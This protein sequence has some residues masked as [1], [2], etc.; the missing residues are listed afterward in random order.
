M[1]HPVT[2]FRERGLRGQK[3]PT[4]PDANGTAKSRA[5]P[6]PALARHDLKYSQA[7]TLR[8]MGPWFP[9]FENHEEWGNLTRVA[10]QQKSRSPAL[11]YFR[12]PFQHPTHVSEITKAAYRRV[13]CGRLSWM[14]DWR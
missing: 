1:Q 3:P 4:L 2:V 13:R 12:S 9:P 10:S 14:I 7:K 11:W 5:L 8:G 6:N